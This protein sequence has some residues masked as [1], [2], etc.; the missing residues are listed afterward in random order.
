MTNEELETIV[1][2]KREMSNMPLN[3]ASERLKI[4]NQMAIATQNGDHE[5]VAD[6]TAKLLEIDELAAEAEQSIGSEKLAIFAQL[7]ARNRDTNFTENREAEKAFNEEKKL[8]G[9]SDYDPFARRK[10]A[11]K[12]VVNR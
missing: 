9:S 3:V 12:H 4:K 8:K 10:T 6:L 11:P 7:N 1:K 5:L 2:L